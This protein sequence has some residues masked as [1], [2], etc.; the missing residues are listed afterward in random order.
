MQQDAKVNY[1]MTKSTESLEKELSL[2]LTTVNGGGLL[3]D[4]IIEELGKRIDNEA[5]KEDVALNKG[6]GTA[7]IK[8]V[9]AFLLDCKNVKIDQLSYYI[10]YPEFIKYF[11]DIAVITKHHLIIGI[12]FSYGWMPKVFRFHSDRFDEVMKFLI[13][14]SKEIYRQRPSLAQ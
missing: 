4:D 7:F 6:E 1:F 8:T 10:T 12:N 13:K 14:P 2:L 5:K 3:A 11:K 9:D